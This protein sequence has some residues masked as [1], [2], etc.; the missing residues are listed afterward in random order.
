MSIGCLSVLPEIPNINL[1]QVPVNLGFFNDFLNRREIFFALFTTGDFVK[2]ALKATECTESLTSEIMP[3]IK[4]TM[5]PNAI[6]FFSVQYMILLIKY[7][8]SL[9]LPD[10]LLNLNRRPSKQSYE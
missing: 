9:L 5:F 4:A 1:L 7:C 10:G 6:A 2:I 8:Y 3:Q